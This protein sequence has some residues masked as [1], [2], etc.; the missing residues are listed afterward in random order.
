MDGW[1]ENKNMKKQMDGYKKQIDG[2]MDG[3]MDIKKQM[4]KNGLLDG[5][6]K[7]DV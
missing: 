1:E 5:Q 4:Y 2:W 3:W 7:I 6:K